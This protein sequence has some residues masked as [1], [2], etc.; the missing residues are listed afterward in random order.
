MKYMCLNKKHKALLP[1]LAA[2][3]KS[4]KEDQ[5]E[6]Y[7]LLA[8]LDGELNNKELFRRIVVAASSEE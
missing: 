2:A 5:K 4:M 7:R 6:G 8:R 1:Q 3:L